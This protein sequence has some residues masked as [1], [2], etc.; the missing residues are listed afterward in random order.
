MAEPATCWCRS[1]YTH[2]HV[3]LTRGDTSKCPPVYHTAESR[4][5]RSGAIHVPSGAPVAI[6]RI[7][8]FDH[9]MFA[10]R[11]LREIKLLR[12]FKWVFFAA[13]FDRRE[14]W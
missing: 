12:H 13:R 10:Q 3:P 14:D 9:A 1:S 8:P 2:H 11:T 5:T 4:L 7:T 6:K